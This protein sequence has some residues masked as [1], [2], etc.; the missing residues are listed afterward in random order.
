MTQRAW[1]CHR[2]HYLNRFW[3]QDASP[4]LKIGEAQMRQRRQNHRN[5]P[6][7]APQPDLFQTRTKDPDWLDLPAE[8]RIAVTNLIARLL[9]EHQPC[10]G[11]DVTGVRHDA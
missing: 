9:R 6:S 3:M 8:T 5:Q 10:N 7:N 2:R 4:A 11:H 1:H